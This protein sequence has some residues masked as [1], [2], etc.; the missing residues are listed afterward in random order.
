MGQKYQRNIVQTPCIKPR[1]RTKSE[2]NLTH[3]PISVSPHK[4]IRM[5]AFKCLSSKQMELTKEWSC[6]S[7]NEKLNRLMEKLLTIH[8]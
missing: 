1:K 7:Q 3:S 6:L 5:T 8:N 2:I 4:Q